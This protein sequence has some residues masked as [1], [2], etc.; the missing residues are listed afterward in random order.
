MLRPLTFRSP[1]RIRRSQKIGEYDDIGPH[2]Y[3]T[4]KYKPR[5][6]RGGSLYVLRYLV[7]KPM[8]KFF[9]TQYKILVAVASYICSACL[10][11]DK[12]YPFETRP[13]RRPR[14]PSNDALRRNG[15]LPRHSLL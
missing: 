13:N 12:L 5:R 8:T 14:I 9:R 15:V 3:D 7:Y 6:L 2:K 10:L 4:V 11:D 1:N